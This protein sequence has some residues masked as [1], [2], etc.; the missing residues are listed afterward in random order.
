MFPRRERSTHVE[1]SD[2]NF[3]CQPGRGAGPR[4]R[5]RGYPGVS[6]GSSWM[7]FTLKGA[8]SKADPLHSVGRL[9]NPSEGRVRAG[10]RGE[11]LL[12]TGPWPQPGGPA[13]ALVPLLMTSLI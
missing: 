4:R 8:L 3:L 13:A 7:S 1:K 6:R 5:V 10:G 9:S 12:P 11:K 2:V